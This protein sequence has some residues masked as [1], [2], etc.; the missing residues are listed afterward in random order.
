MRETYVNS[1]DHAALKQVMRNFNNAVA[2]DH[3]EI[4]S[5]R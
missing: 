5:D 1:S 2:E 3:Y 4:C